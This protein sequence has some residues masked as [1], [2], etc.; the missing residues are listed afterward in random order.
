[1]LQG[2]E[3]SI[4]DGLVELAFLLLQ[5]MT[6]LTIRIGSLYCCIG[7]IIR[8]ENLQIYRKM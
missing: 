5:M 2:A 7:E 6:N 4:T 3:F 1:M 8:E